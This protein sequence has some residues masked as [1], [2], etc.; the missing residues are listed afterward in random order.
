MQ[1][2]PGELWVRLRRSLWQAPR[3]AP[4]VLGLALVILLSIPWGYAVVR[5]LASGTGSPAG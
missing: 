5:R 3:P 4:L 1:D 2:E